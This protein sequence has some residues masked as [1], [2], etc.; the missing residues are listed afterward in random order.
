[1]R[2]NRHT[3]L[4][5][6]GLLIFSGC[7]QKQGKVDR[8]FENGVEVVINHLEPYKIGPAN[9]FD[10][11]EAYKIDTE[12]DDLAPLGIVYIQGFDVDSAGEL[13]ILRSFTGQGDFLFKFDRY[14]KFVKSFGTRGEGPGELQ[15]PFHIFLDVEENIGIFD[16]GR[17]PLNK[18]NR[19]GS[20]IQSSDLLRNAMKV[21]P[22]PGKSWLI[23]ENSHDPA[24]DFNLFALKLLN[25]SLKEIKTIDT[26]GFKME[27]KKLNAIE[28]IFC[29]SS[30]RDYL[31]VANENRGYEI[32]VSDLNGK[33]IRTLRKEVHPTI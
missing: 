21:T 3:F 7:H 24:R 29:W 17:H 9:S 32:W 33:L 5:F 20:F 28:P 12:K 1:M 11:E 23:L 4:L 30:S 27:P 16:R 19:D 14:G 8:A 2:R 6:I 25:S 26:Y 22:G 10:L 15:L 13:F 18:Y 31:Y